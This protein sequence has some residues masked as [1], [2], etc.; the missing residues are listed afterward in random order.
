MKSKTISKTISKTTLKDLVKITDIELLD[1]PSETKTVLTN[2][3]FVEKGEQQVIVPVTIGV[4]MI[5]NLAYARAIREQY[6]E[7]LRELAKDKNDT[8]QDI[9]ASVRVNITTDAK[10]SLVYIVF[11][12]NDLEIQYPNRNTRLK[13]YENDFSITLKNGTI[14]YSK[15]IDI[16]KFSEAIGYDTRTEL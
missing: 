15:V 14:F 1:I 13:I 2:L 10:T 3:A 5:G 9:L 8:L 11:N 4:T 16:Y 7:T 6:L 12:H